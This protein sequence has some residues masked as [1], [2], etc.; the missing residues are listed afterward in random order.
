MGSFCAFRV[1]G[2]AL[3]RGREGERQGAEDAEERQN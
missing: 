2:A 1:E 3:V